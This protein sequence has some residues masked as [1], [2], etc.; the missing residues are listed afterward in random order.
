MKKLLSVL[1]FIPLSIQAKE[2]PQGSKYDNRIQHVTYNENDVVSLYSHAGLSSQIVFSSEEVV[3][4]IGSG[5]S[6]GWEFSDRN[7]IIFI[8]PKSVEIG[9]GQQKQVMP[10]VAGKWDTNIL[11]TTNKRLYAFDLY[12]LPEQKDNSVLDANNKV[13]YR[14]RFHYPKAEPK[15]QASNTNEKLA[16]DIE[17]RNP[18]RNWEYSMQIG[19]NSPSIIP[20]VAYD[21][22]RFTYLTFPNNSNFPAAFLVNKNGTE[23]LVNSHL[24][25]SIP[26]GPKDTLVIHTVSPAFVLR[27]GDEVVGIYNDNFDPYGI[28]PVQGSTNPQKSREI[29]GNRHGE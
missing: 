4:D 8:K 7:N 15:T 13:S 18:P 28:A 6:A 29:K 14:V 24:E 16:A 5:F 19:D 22:G 20:S 27:Y 9:T 3:E 10:P 23:G 25:A 2:I 21:D 26:N 11:V 1:L 12:L 17:T